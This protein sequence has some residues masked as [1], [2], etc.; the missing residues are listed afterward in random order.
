MSSKYVDVTCIASRARTSQT[1][2][3][4]IKSPC[5]FLNVERCT[6]IN[7]SEKN[8]YRTI[9]NDI[10]NHLVRFILFT[11]T[12]KSFS[13]FSIDFMFM[14]STLMVMPD[15]FVKTHEVRHL[16]N[17]S[18]SKNRDFFCILRMFII[19]LGFNNK[20][21]CRKRKCSIPK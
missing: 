12:D 7:Y 9:L 11:S 18:Y 3:I 1:R 14:I 13:F 19:F 16:K 21:Y 20:D 5:I 2:I 8:H 4:N 17:C 6:L 10:L 15:S